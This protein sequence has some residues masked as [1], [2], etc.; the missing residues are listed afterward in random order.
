MLKLGAKCWIW[1]FHAQGSRGIIVAVKVQ[2][3]AVKI[4]V[5]AAEYKRKTGWNSGNH[6]NEFHPTLN[7]NV[8]FCRLFLNLTLC[9]TQKK[10][11][12]W[13]SYKGFL[14]ENI[15]QAKGNK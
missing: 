3:G 10:K 14:L 9:M 8:L 11:A 13:E 6:Q 5:A 4:Y 7:A 2:V 1:A 12:G 15:E